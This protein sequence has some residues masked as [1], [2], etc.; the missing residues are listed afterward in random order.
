MRNSLRLVLDRNTNQLIVAPPAA[1]APLSPMGEGLG[2]RA[3]I[4][5]ACIKTHH[6]A[7]TRAR[8]DGKSLP[9]AWAMADE[10]AR[11]LREQMSFAKGQVPA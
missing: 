2:V 10:A 6:D 7:F 4:D 9:V 11:G 8:Q 1:P 3:S 5:E